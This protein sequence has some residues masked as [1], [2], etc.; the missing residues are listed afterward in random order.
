LEKNIKK[1]V[2]TQR[3]RFD[4]FLILLATGLYL[5]YIKFA[6]A[7]SS[8]LVTLFVMVVFRES[9]IISNYF[10]V[11]TV[12]LSLLGIILAN[13]AE[14]IIGSR[15]PHE[16][17]IDDICGMLISIIGLLNHDFYILF[18]GFLFFRF[19]DNVKLFPINIVENRV[20]GGFGIML[21]DVIAA[22]YANFS[23]RLFLMIYKA[24]L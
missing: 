22:I 20:N 17:V 15:D 8:S 9:Y 18:L 5:G 23:I 16:I 1:K 4:K 2:I 10:L 3:T 12:L 21:D 7:A 14:K 11:F 19:Y 24:L 6:P 13:V